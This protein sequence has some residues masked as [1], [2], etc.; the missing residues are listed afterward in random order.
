MLT[1]QELFLLAALACFVIFAVLY[2]VQA[3][4]VEGTR[5]LWLANLLGSA[6]YVLYA[7]DETLPEILTYEV[8]NL[9]YTAA[10]AAALVGFR[11]LLG[12]S[13]SLPLI[14]LG[15]LLTASV[16]AFFHYAV[17][18]FAMRT[19]AVSGFQAVVA[20]AITYTVVTAHAQLRSARY[21]LAFSA[22]TAMIISFGHTIRVLAQLSMPN[23]SQSLLEP[24]G[25]MQMFLAMGVFSHP[26]L[27]LGGLLVI[28]RIIV[29]MA[30]DA[31]NH[32]YLTGVRSRRAFFDIADRELARARRTGRPLA[33]M[34]LDVDHFKSINDKYGHAAGDRAL[35]TFVGTVSQCLRGTDYLARL[36]G[37]EFAVVMPDTGHAGACSVARRLYQRLNEKPTSSPCQITSCI[38]TAVVRAEDDLHSLIER[39][40]VSLYKAKEAGRNRAAVGFD[41]SDRC[42]GC[43]LVHAPDG[44]ECA[45]LASA[46]A[47]SSSRLKVVSLKA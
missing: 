28:H 23:A 20:M 41:V 22:L 31:V 14:A 42:S 24:V 6:A 4:R 36:G 8:A 12:R 13:V 40:D 11:R 33:V 30:E 38:G 2:S 39:A 3:C 17:Y 15:L 16:T 37:D 35:R 26:V 9:S 43:S 5:E 1:I 29:V 25:W 19:I 27:T 18:S 34:M 46:P 21:A 7:F 47:G 10:G 45:N 44:I 32:D